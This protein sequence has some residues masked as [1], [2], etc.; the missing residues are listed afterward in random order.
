MKKKTKKVQN[1]GATNFENTF[2]EKS[3]A[4]LAHSA[5]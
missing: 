2:E 4:I 1:L 5:L 3:Q